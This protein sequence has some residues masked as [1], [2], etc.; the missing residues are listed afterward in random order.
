MVPKSAAKRIL[1]AGWQHIVQVNKNARG[2][3]AQ[4]QY[5]KFACRKSICEIYV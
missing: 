3:Q 4:N 2:D 1:G 5:M